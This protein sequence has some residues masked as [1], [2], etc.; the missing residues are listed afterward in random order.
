MAKTSSNAQRIVLIETPAT[1]LP[2]EDPDG[3]TSTIVQFPVTSTSSK[4]ENNVNGTSSGRG[5]ETTP[6]AAEIKTQDRSKKKSSLGPAGLWLFDDQSESTKDDKNPA[7]TARRKDSKTRKDNEN[8]AANT[9]RKDSKT[10]KDDT[11]SKENAPRKVSKD[12]SLTRKDGKNLEK[13]SP[14]KDSKD[15]NKAVSKEEDKT[16]KKTS[17]ESGSSPMTDDKPEAF[18]DDYIRPSPQDSTEA[19]R[20][21]SLTHVALSVYQETESPA[22]STEEGKPS[23]EVKDVN[24]QNQE[25]GSLQDQVTNDGTKQVSNDGESSKENEPRSKNSR[26]ENGNKKEEPKVKKKTVHRKISSWLFGDDEEKDITQKNKNENKKDDKD[27]KENEAGNDNNGEK[28]DTKANEEINRTDKKRNQI[29]EKRDS[30]KVDVDKDEIGKKSGT[31]D[32]VTG[33]A[34]KDENVTKEGKR[35][36]DDENEDVDGRNMEMIDEEAE[37][38]DDDDDDEVGDDDSDDDDDDDDNNNGGEAQ[39]ENSGNGGGATTGTRGRRGSKKGGRRRKKIGFGKLKWNAQSKVD[40]GSTSYKPKT[41]V[42]KIPHFKNDYTHVKSRISTLTEANTTE[43]A[44]DS[45]TTGRRQRSI[46]FNKSPDYS[47]VRPRLY[48]GTPRKY[49]S[50][51]PSNLPK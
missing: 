36:G 47:N 43:N 16:N 20:R 24:E 6:A 15:S 46:S 11:N 31:S 48:N 26:D 28:G 3:F 27:N 7:K 13:N 30:V 40:T 38:S 44:V 39:D 51:M 45:P 8:A 2:P 22:K 34:S 42:K 12:N 32:D 41:S 18:G 29:D 19:S 17:L 1:P 33:E 50:E 4:S 9:P 49:N 21:A 23:K 37:D 5:M 25:Q 35:G 10:E 14:R